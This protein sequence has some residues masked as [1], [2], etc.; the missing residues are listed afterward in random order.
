MT[1]PFLYNDPEQVPDDVNLSSKQAAA[2]SA[3]KPPQRGFIF[4]QNNVPQYRLLLV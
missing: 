4:I 3:A 2:R 1:H